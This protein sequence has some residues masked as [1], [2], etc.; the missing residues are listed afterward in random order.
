MS[1]LTLII[2]NK[3]SSSWSL[4][5]WL[6]LKQIGVPFREITIP[7]RQPET[8][9][10]ILQHS[11]AG[12]V[13]VLR[14]GDLT[15]YDS[16]AILEYLAESFPEAG[17]WP[18]DR[19]ARA[20]ARSISAEMHSGFVDLRRNMPMDVTDKHPA[21][22]R[23]PEV[24]ADIAR[25]TQIWRDARARFGADGPF[26]FGHFSAADAMYAPVCTRLDTYVV[27]LDEVSQAYV[28]TVLGLP[29]M[30]EWYAAGAAEPWGPLL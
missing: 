11:P 22:G 17:L 24:Q 29:A 26:L 8:K 5:P 9:A 12:K 21:E 2:G 1:D 6:A 13:P 27:D 4:R 15:V 25:I 19:G 16:L 28:S 3:A 10:E 18:D 23:T 14:D 7:L 20:V 30:R